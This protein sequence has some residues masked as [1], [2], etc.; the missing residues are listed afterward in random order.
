M[1]VLLNRRRTG[2]VN[3]SINFLYNNAH[4]KRLYVT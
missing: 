2:E 3:Q 1:K 4:A